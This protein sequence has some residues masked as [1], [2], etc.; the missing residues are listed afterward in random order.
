M[1]RQ[2]GHFAPAGSSA[3]RPSAAIGRPRYDAAGP[4]WSIVRVAIAVALAAILA[5][6]LHAESH[7]AAGP[8]AA[9]P[10]IAAKP[11]PRKGHVPPYL[12]NR[13]GPVGG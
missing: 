11:E 3:G 7:R 6:W 10:P 12:P 13:T 4:S 8:T 5:I 1:D 2:Q 9:A